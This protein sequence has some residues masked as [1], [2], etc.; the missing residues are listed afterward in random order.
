VRYSAFLIL[1]I[2][3]N[4]VIVSSNDKTTVK[5][6]KKEIVLTGYTRNIKSRIVSSEISGIVLIVNYDVG[7]IIDDKPFIEIDPTFIDFQIENT[8]MSL[9]KIVIIV[10]KAASRVSY[11]EKESLRIE[12]LHKDDMATEAK[13]DAVLQELEQARLDLDSTSKERD[14]LQTNLNELMERKNRHSIYAPDGFV[15]TE[16]NV[17]E[18]EVV[19]PGIPLAK[20]SDYRKLVVPLSV[21]N[22]ELSAIKS[23]PNVFDAEMEGN[24]VKVSVNW[25]NPEFDEKTRKLKME[26]IINNYK[27]MKRGGLKL[28]L[29]LRIKTEGLYIPKAAVTD[30]Y[31]NPTVTIKQTGEII[32]LLVIEESEDN[33]LAVED[34]RL[35]PGTELV[36][37]D[38]LH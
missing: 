25:I 15:V 10:K 11:L 6:A 32:Q 34:K 24:P 14:I 2:L 28:T 4:P 16:R 13:K 5:E 36:P 19:Q 12:R 20:V 18:G 7:Q 1:F 8:M 23:L 22:E 35:L 21:S 29:P 33:L 17:E 37:A 31:E 26:L 27:G 38:K 9:E 30:R 3:L